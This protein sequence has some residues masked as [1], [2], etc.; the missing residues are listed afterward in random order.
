MGKKTTA[1]K[2]T[3]ADDTVGKESTPTCSWS[4][5]SKGCLMRGVQLRDV[6]GVDGCDSV[7]HHMFQT[8]WEMYQ[9]HVEIPDGDPKDCIYDSVGKK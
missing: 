4:I 1:V 7:F 6:C 3:A 9:Y 5:S 8:E 2:S